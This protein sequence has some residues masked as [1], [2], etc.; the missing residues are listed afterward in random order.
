M[1]MDEQAFHPFALSGCSSSWPLGRHLEWKAIVAPAR[2][3][4]T[5]VGR[6]LDC[7]GFLAVFIG[8]SF[9]CLS[10]VAGVGVSRR[11]HPQTGQAGHHRRRTRS[12]ICRLLPY[13]ARPGLRNLADDDKVVVNKG[14]VSD[15]FLC[16][17]TLS[18]D[19][20]CPSCLVKL[21][22]IS[23]ISGTPSMT[24]RRAVQ[25]SQRLAVRTARSHPNRQLLASKW[26]V[27]SC[28]SCRIHFFLHPRRRQVLSRS[29]THHQSSLASL[30]IRQ[31][32]MISRVS[33]QLC[34]GDVDEFRGVSRVRGS[35][36]TKHP[37]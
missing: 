12:S 23:A 26:C 6:K 9:Q 21:R 28:Q 3:V 14:V 13:H 2:K 29:A 22:I 34:V 5:V 32:W 7:T 8:C 4:D 25:F 36:R 20:L 24:M 15:V 31:G 11:T 35:L 10:A 33:T 27:L 37:R 19:Q 1:E 16:P 30:D 18:H 17:K